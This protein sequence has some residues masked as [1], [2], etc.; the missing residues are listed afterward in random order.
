[1]GLL[2]GAVELERGFLF[3][4]KTPVWSV[5]EVSVMLGMALPELPEVHQVGRGQ[6][7]SWSQ[8]H[9][10]VTFTQSLAPGLIP[11]AAVTAGQQQLPGKL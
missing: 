7:H 5:P 10:P 6:S 1:M 3:S 8:E 9:Q 4:C 11:G 2:H